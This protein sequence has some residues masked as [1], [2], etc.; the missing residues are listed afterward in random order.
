MISDLISNLVNSISEKSNEVIRDNDDGSSTNK[1]TSVSAANKASGTKTDNN[2][3][4]SA[5]SATSKLEATNI[6]I[7]IEL[8]LPSVVNI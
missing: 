8:I 6:A 1:F 3:A 5:K 7:N 2:A 4:S